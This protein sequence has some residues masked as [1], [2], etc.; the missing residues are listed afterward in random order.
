MQHSWGP[1]WYPGSTRGAAQCQGVLQG[2]DCTDGF[3]KPLQI[4]S[5]KLQPISARFCFDWITS[6]IV[7]IKV[8]YKMVYIKPMA[9]LLGTHVKSNATTAHT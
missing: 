4:G 7:S 6:T 1:G 2:I 9:A 8:H 3:V 5:Q